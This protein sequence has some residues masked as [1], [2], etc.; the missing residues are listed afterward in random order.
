MYR[1]FPYSPDSPIPRFPD[2][3]LL[4]S[5]SIRYCITIYTICLS[6]AMGPQK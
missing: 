6:T 3:T 4:V 2:S 1:L 5:G